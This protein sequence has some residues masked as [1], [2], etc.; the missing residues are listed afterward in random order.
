MIDGKVDRLKQYDRNPGMS[1]DIFT[2]PAK[3]PAKNQE[4]QIDN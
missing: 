1:A 4:Y 2:G 3:N